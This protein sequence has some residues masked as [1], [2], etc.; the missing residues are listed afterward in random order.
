MTKTKKLT[1]WESVMLVA[2][3]GIGT[4]IITI[5]YA[6][7]QIGVFGAATALLSAFVVSILT[8]LILADLVRNSTQSDDLIGA[9]TEHLCKGKGRKFFSVLFLV[10]LAL[11]L[12]E[13]LVVYSLCAGD[14]LSDLLGISRA[15]SI[16]IFYFLAS[17]I[18]F[19]GV[20]GM[21]VGEKISVLLIGAV[22]IVLTVLAFFHKNG[23]FP[24][25][26]GDPGKV[27]AVYGLFMYS[28][29]S[30]FAVIQTCNHIEKPEQTGKAI[31]AGTAVNA[32]ITAVFS[33]AVIIGSKAVTE[34]ATIGLSDGIGIPFVKVLCSILI[35]GAMFTS[36][37]SIGFA[38]SDVV[39]NRFKLDTRL[40]WLITTVPA[41]LLAVLLPLSILNYVQI[42][43]G[44]LSIVFL[45]VVFPAYK[46]AVSNPIQPPLLGK[47]S[48]KWPL[49]LFVVI[50][51]VLM[52]VSSLIPVS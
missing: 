42:G 18:V 15:V 9:L 46:Y 10:L 23:S 24:L 22:V 33:I 39:S 16:L 5:P 11:L 1:F 47:F 30:T 32:G 48:G 26:F 13:F 8:Y 38:F 45:A 51:T 41:I 12:L 7:S 14:V 25:I 50:G 4:G 2:G 3:A 6:I 40:S 27:F 36:F 34:T 19:F 37:W 31:I 49:L 29:S 35:I 17:L 44:A 28:M 43:A 20:K 21:G 52:A